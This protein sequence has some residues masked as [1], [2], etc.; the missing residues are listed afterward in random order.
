MIVLQDEASY[1]ERRRELWALEEIVD[2]GVA[3]L[4]KMNGH[5]ALRPALQGVLEAL[6]AD[7]GRLLDFYLDRHLTVRREALALWEEHQS[8]RACRSTCKRD[9]SCGGAGR[10]RLGCLAGAAHS[11][12]AMTRQGEEE[13]Q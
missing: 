8:W 5:A 12:D 6:A 1:Q 7:L 2:D 9:G 10:H 13:E 11:D 4:A 3:L